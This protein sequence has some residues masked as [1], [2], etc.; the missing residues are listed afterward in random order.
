MDLSISEDYRKMSLQCAED[1]LKIILPLAR[2]VICT[3]SGNTPKGMYEELIGKIKKTN[4]DITNWYFI[5]LD[6]WAGM[7]GNDEGSCRYHLNNDLFFALDIPED[8]ICFFDGRAG[9]LQAE[10]D[11]IERYI[12]SLGGLDVAILG[13]GLNGHVGM[14]EPGTDTDSRSRVIELHNTTIKAAQKYFAKEQILSQGLTLGMA[15][16]TGAANLML[17]VSG[18]DKASIVQKI[19]TSNMDQELPATLLTANRSL[20]MY[21]DTDAASL[22]GLIKNEQ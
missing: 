13:L 17:L 15:T 21:L 22:T 1:F 19:I 9:N 4:V 8:H 5:G 14:N 10:C 12:E 6:E 16:L 20:K 2:P 11:H 18:I 3:A 7:N